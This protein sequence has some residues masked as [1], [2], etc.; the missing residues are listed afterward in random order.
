MKLLAEGAEASIYLEDGRIVKRRHRKGYRIKE[1]D[2]KLRVFRTKREAKVME[3]LRGIGVAV[4]KLLTADE[5]ETA[6]EMEFIEGKKL[7]DML[8]GSN[9]SEIA[10]AIG[11]KTAVMHNNSIIHGD[12]T[13]SNMIFKRNTVYL[14]DFGLS[15]FSDKPEDKAVDIHLFR[16]ALNSSHSKLAGRCFSAFIKG[17]EEASRSGGEVLKRLEKVEGRGRNKGKR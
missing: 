2:E 14:I 9:C 11:E 5:K 13:T 3:K 17:Y 6:L 12:L 15:F 1:L 10:R 7:K 4:P 16:Q 8:S